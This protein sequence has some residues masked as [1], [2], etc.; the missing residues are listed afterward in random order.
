[1]PKGIYPR[2]SDGP[3]LPRCMSRQELS[4][5]WTFN[6]ECD[7]RAMAKSPCRDCVQEFQLEM[8][9]EGKCERKR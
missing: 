5:W 2:P 1:M 9:L 3:P 6:L 7:P 4:E 8:L